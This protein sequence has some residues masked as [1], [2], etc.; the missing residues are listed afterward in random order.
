MA[1]LEK[2]TFFPKVKNYAF[3]DCDAE[4]WL[5]FQG[6]TS[7]GFAPYDMIFHA[8]SNETAIPS[9]MKPMSSETFK[10][11]QNFNRS[12][13]PPFDYRESCSCQDC[14][15]VCPADAEFPTDSERPTI[16]TLDLVAFISI[17]IWVLVATVFIIGELLNRR[18]VVLKRQ[19]Q[20]TT[21]MNEFLLKKYESWVEFLLRHSLLTVFCCVS[22]AAFLLSGLL[23]VNFTTDPIELWTSSSS[24]SYKEYKK[25]NNYFG[26]FYRTEQVIATLKAEYRNG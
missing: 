13:F 3:L 9:G 19:N 24:R 20:C 2:V 5:N 11:Y 12:E 22:L 7:N 1:K 4:T 14:S 15:E 16:G 26:P 10:C 8:T 23:F 21:K 18:R 6:S 25:F 17:L